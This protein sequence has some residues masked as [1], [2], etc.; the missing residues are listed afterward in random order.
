MKNK[1][2]DFIFNVLVFVLIVLFVVGYVWIK[3]SKWICSTPFGA[4][5]VRCVGKWYH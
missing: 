4:N 1:Q 3:N 5:D 2:K